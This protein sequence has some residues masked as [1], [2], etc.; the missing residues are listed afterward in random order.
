LIGKLCRVPIYPLLFAT[1]P[2]LALFA[3]NA[4]EVRAAELTTLLALAA[5]G[6]GAAWLLAGLLVKDAA[7]G[8]LIAALAIVM[9]YSLGFVL[10]WAGAILTFLSDYWIHKPRVEAGPLWVLALELLLLGC[11]GRRLAGR[12]P[13]RLRGATGFL[14]AV[15]VIAVALSAIQVLSIKAPA[16]TRTPRSPAP[17]A[18]LAPSTGRLPDIYYIILDGYAR[19]D[20]LKSHFGLDNTP[21]L[22]H[23]ESKGFFVA[24]SSTANYAQTPLCLSASLNG[25]YLDEMVK[26]LGNDQTELKEFIGHSDV[27]A[28][29]Q[30]LGYRFVSFATGFEP[31][32]NPEADRYL[33][34]HPYMTEFQRMVVDMTPARVIWPDPR[35]MD[36]FH[37]A[38][39]RATYLLEHLPDVAKD[40]RPTFTFAHLLCPQPPIVFGANGEDVGNRLEP[41]M[42]FNRKVNGRFPRP[43]EF[44]RAYRD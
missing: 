6:A 42:L 32:E 10:E 40:S 18:R 38:R 20:V 36:R 7:K 1:Y 30:P 44:R 41:F 8:A 15:G 22:E 19:H 5:A 26:G 23:L 3:Q 14:N 21:F 12:Y 2:I 11:L 35:Q 43:E 16:A 27:M 13:G 39:D 31:T 4:R 9:F 28:S 29:L 24:R 37:R 17:L 33:S 25:T 34:P